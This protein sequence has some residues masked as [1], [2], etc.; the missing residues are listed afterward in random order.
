MYTNDKVFELAAGTAAKKKA[1]VQDTS[2]FLLPQNYLEKRQV[3]KIR[4]VAVR[5]YAP[6]FS[7]IRSLKS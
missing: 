1:L 3:R 2:H 7:T 5:M 4:L 6:H